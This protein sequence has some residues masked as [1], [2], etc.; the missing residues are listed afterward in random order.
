MPL[1]TI[2]PVS[3][4]I[5]SKVICRMASWARFNA[6]D[7]YRNSRGKI[8]VKVFTIRCKRILPRS[9]RNAALTSKE[10]IRVTSIESPRGERVAAADFPVAVAPY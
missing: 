2:C 6:S 4:S 9:L 5:I 10:S 3:R 1:Q 8:T 7:W